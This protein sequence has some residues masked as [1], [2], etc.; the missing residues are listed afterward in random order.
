VSGSAEILFPMP[1]A[2][3]DRTLRLAAFIDAGQVYGVNEK[4]SLGELRYSAGVAL[5]WSSPFGPLKLSLA[6]PLNEKKGFD[7]VERLQFNF[8]TAF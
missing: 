6:Q 5:A 3:Q 8:G 1:G 4:L 2:N 7:R